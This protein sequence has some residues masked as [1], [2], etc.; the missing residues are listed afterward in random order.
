MES[1]RGLSKDIS[2]LRRSMERPRFDLPKGWPLHRTSR[3]DRIND[4]DRCGGIDLV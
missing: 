4:R 2:D 3:W 1:V